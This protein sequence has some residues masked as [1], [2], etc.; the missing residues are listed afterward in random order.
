MLHNSVEVG[1]EKDVW[2]SGSLETV[3]E[4]WVMRGPA[5]SIHRLRACRVQTRF[6]LTT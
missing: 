4:L 1:S 6:P 5:G 2:V 3:I